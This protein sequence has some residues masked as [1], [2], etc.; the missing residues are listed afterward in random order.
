MRRGR[1]RSQGALYGHR[2]PWKPR[3]WG[4]GTEQADAGQNELIGAAPHLPFVQDDGDPVSSGG[5]AVGAGVHVQGLSLFHVGPL[6]E[7]CPRRPARG[8]WTSSRAGAW[9]PIRPP[10]DPLGGPDGSLVRCSPGA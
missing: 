4:I 5:G 6:V 9:V 2:A 3:P 10:P 7:G 8:T 1:R